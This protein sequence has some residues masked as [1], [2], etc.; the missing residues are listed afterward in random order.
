MTAYARRQLPRVTAYL[1]THIDAARQQGEQYLQSWA[2]LPS[3]LRHPYSPFSGVPLGLD[4]LSTLVPFPMI[5]FSYSAEVE[6]Q[7]KSLIR[8]AENA[9]REDEGLPRVGEGWISETQLY[10]EITSA[11]PNDEVVQHASP[12][13]LG[14]QHLDVYLPGRRIALEYHGL[15]H[16]QP[17]EFF[18]GAEAFAKTV[19]RDRAKRTKC[20]KE[21]VLLIEVRPGYSLEQVIQQ[22]AS[23]K[24][25]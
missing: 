5:G 3:V 10:Y 19:A 13:W 21:G 7:C 8:Q 16:D 17:V 15:Q 20:D 24:F 14:R 12:E 6:Q 4:N 9:L 2:R 25:E 22:I 1:D 11:F 18:G 23:H